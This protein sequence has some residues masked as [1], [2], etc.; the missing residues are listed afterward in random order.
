MPER[1]IAR[2]S[3]SSTTATGARRCAS[4]AATGATATPTTSSTARSSG[5]WP[6][7]CAAAVPPTPSAPTCSSPSAGWR[8][9]TGAG[10]TTRPST[11]CP[12]PSPRPWTCHP[13]TG[14]SAT[15][16]SRR[17]RRSPSGG[18]RCSGSPRSRGANPARWGGR[19]ACPPTRWRCWPTGRG[20]DCA[21]PTCR[22]TSSRHRA[23][24]VNRT[25]PASAVTCGG[26][27]V[28]AAV[29]V[30]AAVVTAVAALTV[31][32][33]PF[34]GDRPS[35]ERPTL[36]AGAPA[37]GD[38]GDEPAARDVTAGGAQP[39]QL[40]ESATEGD[41]ASTSGTI[42]T[43]TA[44]PTGPAAASPEPA[45]AADSLVDLGL[46]IGVGPD[47]GVGVD[48]EVGPDVT[49]DATWALGLLGS[50]R[51]DVAV[52][53]SGT[54]AALLLA[55]DVRLSPDARVRSLLGTGCAPAGGL[56][57]VLGLLRSLSCGIG[58]LAAGAG[59]SLGIPLQVAAAGQ[60]RDHDPALR[61]RCA[62]HHR[63]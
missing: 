7:C 36:E 27:G 53:N 24:A 35:D 25:G 62:R 26:G 4:P 23:G 52:R 44:A 47:L 30:G 6:P 56:D 38:R 15:W 46:G 34:G 3:R 63:G 20:S 37:D 45:P 54:A 9:R 11:S 32:I 60:T 51:L 58:D 33:V 40:A 1:V 13:S 14:P 55:L 28:S 41:E 19:R 8:W 10:R 43:G 31:T 18:R 39:P 16:S 59:A 50:G 22:P 21:R 5:C 49:I 29:K 17:S 2:P 48:V 42:T 61:S 12:T 57:E